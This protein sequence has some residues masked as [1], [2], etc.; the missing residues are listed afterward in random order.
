LA[1][2]IVAGRLIVI[3]ATG[4]AHAFC[5]G[6]FVIDEIVVAIGTSMPEL[7]TAVIAPVRGHE[8]ID[9]GTVQGS[10]LFNGL[11]IVA[12]AAIITPIAV[13]WQAVGLG[14]GVV[15]V[16]CLFPGRNGLLTR[17]RGALLLALYVVYVAIMLT[18]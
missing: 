2:L 5:L 11:W 4:V 15:T 12:V 9:L 18:H 10:N 7:A 8:E 17:K 14:F 3:G 6:E 16:A 13:A 1:L